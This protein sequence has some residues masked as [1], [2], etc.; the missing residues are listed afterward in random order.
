MAEQMLV[1][2]KEEIARR[3]EAIY[4]E[5]RSRLEQEHKGKFVAIEVNTREY[6]IGKTALEAMEKAR[7]KFPYQVSYVIRIGY[8]VVTVFRR[9]SG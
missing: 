4:A 7:Q 6:F 9:V 2:D 8:P 5:I 1:V 3:G